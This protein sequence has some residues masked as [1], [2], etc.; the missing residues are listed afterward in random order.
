MSKST[1]PKFFPPPELA[2]PEGVVLFGGRLTPEL[3]AGRLRA[4][5]FFPGRSFTTPTSSSGGRPIP[6]PSSSCRLAHQ[7]PSVANRVRAVASK[8]RCNRDFAGVIQG[9]ATA[10]G[11]RRQYLAHARHDR[12][13]LPPARAGP[14][15]QRRGLARRPAGRRHLR[16][17]H[18]GGCSPASRCFTASATPRKWRWCI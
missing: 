18:A 13:L 12:R 3:A 6:A 14:C 4:T 8:L 7:P 2:E 10:G 11:R 15:P 5:G 1:Q 17:R 9:C 16:R